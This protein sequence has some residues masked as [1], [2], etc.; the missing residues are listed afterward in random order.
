MLMGGAGP[1]LDGKA[2]DPLKM[3]GV[4]RD[5]HH[6][7]M[8]ADAGNHE[9]HSQCCPGSPSSLLRGDTLG[10]QWVFFDTRA[11]KSSILETKSFRI[12]DVFILL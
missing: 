4:I 6:A 12:G 1:I 5:K 10:F 2:F 11:I 9:V 3:P 7:V 8:L